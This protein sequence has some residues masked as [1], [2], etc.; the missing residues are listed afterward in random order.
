MALILKVVRLLGT[1][2][3]YG[4]AFVTRGEGKKAVFVN[5]GGYSTPKKTDGPKV[6]CDDMIG[7]GASPPKRSTKPFIEDSNNSVINY[8]SIGTCLLFV[9]FMCSYPLFLLSQVPVYDGRYKSGSPFRFAPSDFDAINTWPL[10]H[11]GQSEV[12]EG[13]MVA[14]GYT[15]NFFTVGKE[16]DIAP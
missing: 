9:C 14:V 2:S 15:T 8:E 13:S 6:L 16:P 3:C 7:A 1:T 10:F 5:H 12:P 11:G 4:H